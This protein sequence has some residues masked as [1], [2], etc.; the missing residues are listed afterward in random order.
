MNLAKFAKKYQSLLLHREKNHMLKDL[1]RNRLAAGNIKL[2]NRN[3]E[4]VPESTI[5]EEYKAIRNFMSHFND[6]GERIV[7]IKMV[8]D[9]RYLL[10]ILAC[11]ETGM[12][13]IPLEA[14][15][16][17]SRIDQIK[18]DSQF[19][20]LITEENFSEILSFNKDLK[21]TN[22]SPD[23][24]AYIMFTSG[25]TG[26]PKGVIIPRKALQNF[27]TWLD[28]T[29]LEISTHDHLLQVTDFTFDI[30]LVDVGLFLQKNV[31]LH[32]SNF[33]SNMFKLAFEIESY[34]ISV[35]NTVPNNLNMFLSELVA[36]RTNYESLKHLFIAGS[37]FSLGLYEKCK[38][39][40][41]SDVRVHN[42]YGPTEC[43]VYSHWKTLSFDGKSDVS[44]SNV[45]IGRPLLNV[46]SI[47][48]Q[49]EKVM[50]VH[51]RG[52]LYLTGVQLMKGYVN[53]PE[54]TQKS[55]ISYQGKTFYRTGDIA[56]QDEKGD[57][58]IVGR[59]DDTI[60]YRGF[61]INL[62]DIDSYIQKLP[63]VQ[64][65]ATVAVENEQLET[66][67]VCYMI[68]TEKK[69]VK[70]VKK[71]L[72]AFLLDFQIPEKILFVDSFPVNA[73]GKVDRKALRQNYLSSKE[74]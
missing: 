32:F 12:T 71:D 47:I 16:P 5:V 33:Q 66:T 24:P 13:Y 1:V 48:V 38:K 6:N 9:Y 43:T 46:D 62:L 2:F 74:A 64:D 37:R 42:L 3:G 39:Y 50:G 70:E 72:A 49:D 68:S 61:R 10:T 14:S 60:K 15:Y 23:H 53:N 29:F 20:M 8:K 34:K 22:P 11:Q 51:E 41:R 35:L 31:A 21:E 45:S 58:Y 65:V 69:G 19:K 26:K 63:Y 57:Y 30:S 17:Q 73:S 54:Q 59:V 52:E 55:L 36:E 18:E 25:S 27:Y 56:F 44:E 40:F 7:A 4:A 67:T 28:Q